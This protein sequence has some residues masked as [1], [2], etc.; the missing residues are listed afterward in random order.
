MKFDKPDQLSPFLT[1]V[2]GEFKARGTALRRTLS[3]KTEVQRILKGKSLGGTTIGLPIQYGVFTSPEQVTSEILGERVALKFAHGW[4]AKGVMLLERTSSGRYFD[5]LSLREWTLGEIRDRQCAIAESFGHPEP[6]WIAEEFLRGPQP[7]GIPF[8]YKFYMFKGQIGLVLQIDRNSWPPR[9]AILN[10]DLQPF[11][12]D[13]DYKIATEN[14]QSGVP[15]VP[16]SAVMLS[17]WAIELSHMTDA[18][19]V[20]VDLYDTNSG[21]VFGEFTFSPGATYKRSIMFS[22][23][24]LAELD[25][26]FANAQKQLRG[27]SVK[28]SQSW[29]TVIQ[30]TE[31]NNLVAHPRLSPAEYGRIAYY[32][33]NQGGRGGFRLADAQIGLLEAGADATIN[34]YLARAH[35][36]TGDWVKSRHKLSAAVR[37]EAVR[38]VIEENRPVEEVAEEVGFPVYRLVELV[39][40]AASETNSTGE[41]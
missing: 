8:D 17:R 12:E 38:Q 27:E 22:H 19:F 5:N 11:V 32:L 28:T 36:A 3:T 13:R 2:A 23:A 4:S 15:L 26:L 6:A 37:R 35:H 14:M 31:P 29:S 25:G 20:S 33:Y 30:S 16:R 21:P 40:N 41:K 39:K 1:F 7:G 9:V 24:V 10:G 18:P 34:R